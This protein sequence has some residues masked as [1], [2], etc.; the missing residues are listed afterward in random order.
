MSFIL[1]SVGTADLKKKETIDM[2][3]LPSWTLVL[4]GVI[5]VGAGVLGVIHAPPAIGKAVWSVVV[6]VGLGVLL[7]PV[8]R[9]RGSAG[10]GR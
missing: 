10:E 9:R 4:I 7:V 1:E 2:Q 5:A 8:R 6:L 3:R